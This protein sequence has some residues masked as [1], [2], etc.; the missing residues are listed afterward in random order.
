MEKGWFVPSR[1]GQKVLDEVP[2]P[3]QHVRAQERIGVGLD[4]HPLINNAVRPQ[5]LLGQYDAAV[6][7]AM[8]T[9]EER[10]RELAAAGNEDIG[11]N[12]MKRTF[13]KEGPLRDEDADAGEADAQ[14]APSSG[15]RSAY[16]RIP[17]PTAAC[18]TRTPPRPPRRSSLPISFYEFSTESGGVQLYIV[19]G[20]P[21]VKPLARRAAQQEEQAPAA[22]ASREAERQQGGVGNQKDKECHEARCRESHLKAEDDLLAGQ[23]EAISISSGLLPPALCPDH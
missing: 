12:L 6:L 3:V 1:L 5:F 20:E 18:I 15:E 22:A 2:D 10:V 21:E 9:V 17:R 4:L 11:V 16:S 14:M 23:I 19:T 7:I 8:R 13:A